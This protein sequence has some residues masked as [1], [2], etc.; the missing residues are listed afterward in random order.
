MNGQRL[1]SLDYPPARRADVLDHY[2]G[3][4][5]ADPYRWM[6]HLNSPELHQEDR[7]G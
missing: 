3:S 7:D 5:V 6:E 4:T 1:P 2:F